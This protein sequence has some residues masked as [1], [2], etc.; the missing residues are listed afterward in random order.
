M[1]G[2]VQASYLRRTTQSILAAVTVLADGLPPLF[3]SEQYEQREQPEQ[4]E[5]YEQ[6]EQSEHA[7]TAYVADLKKKTPAKIDQSRFLPLAAGK[8][9]ARTP[10]K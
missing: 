1:I 8:S 3:L 6:R 4:S 5:Q 2:D 7:W 9:N 10:A